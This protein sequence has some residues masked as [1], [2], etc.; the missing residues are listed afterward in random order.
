MP[1]DDLDFSRTRIC[2][3]CHKPIAHDA[4]ICYFCGEDVPY[5]DKPSRPW[6]TITAIIMVIIFVAMIF[7]H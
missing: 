1:Q 7:F 2:P 3:H 5:E 4:T 6:V